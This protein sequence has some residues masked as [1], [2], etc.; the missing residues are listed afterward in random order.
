MVVTRIDGGD[1]ESMWLEG[2]GGG[3]WL[4]NSPTGFELNYGMCHCWC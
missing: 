1:D 3:G 2:G 4:G